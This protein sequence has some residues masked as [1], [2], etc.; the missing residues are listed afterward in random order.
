MRGNLMQSSRLYY[1][2]LDSGQR[3]T[4]RES[5][6]DICGKILCSERDTKEADIHTHTPTELDRALRRGG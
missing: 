4:S 3:E 6:P 5:P 2:L 1:L